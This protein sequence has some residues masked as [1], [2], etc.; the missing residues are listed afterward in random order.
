[1]PQRAALNKFIN[2]FKIELEDLEED[3]NDLLEILEERKNSQEITNYVYI[4]N[5]GVLLNE[6]SCVR[7]LLDR[8]STIDAYQYQ[9]VE[10]MV[11]GVKEMLDRR[12]VDC[13]FPDA[14][15]SLVQR[16]LEKVCTYVL[17]PETAQS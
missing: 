9:N 7:E 16:K 11:A 14:V 13:S 5:K 12:I 2:I 1:M 10:A 8:L 4:A 17:G 3:I 15:H 6:I